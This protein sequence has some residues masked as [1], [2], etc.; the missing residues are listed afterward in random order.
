MTYEQE[1]RFSLGYM[2]ARRKTK[3]YI[4]GKLWAISMP[5]HSDE[6]YSLG[7]LWCIDRVKK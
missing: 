7:Y 5:E 6:F 2:H 4:D 3:F 1:S